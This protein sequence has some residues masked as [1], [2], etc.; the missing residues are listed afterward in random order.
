MPKFGFVFPGQGSQALKMMDGFANAEIIKSVF[1]EASSILDL[2]FWGMLQED[3]PAQINQTLNT[4][5]LLLTASV[6]IYQAWLDYSANCAPDFVAGHSL[7]EYSA[8]VA[9][10][11]LTFSTALKLVQKRAQYMQEAVK[12]GA[13]AMAAVLGLTNA[14]V[15]EVCAEVMQSGIGVVQG[16]NFNAEGQVVI[17]GNTPAVEQAVGLMKAKGARKIILLSVS[18]PSHCD[19]MREAAEQL[20]LEFKQVSFNQPSIP[21]IQNVSGQIVNDVLA[22]KD[23]LVQQ[24][25]SPVLWS[26]SVETL[27]ANRVELI[28]ECG[29]GKVLSGLNKRIHPNAQLFS[30]H[31]LADMA[32]LVQVLNLGESK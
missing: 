23:G 19:L 10:G 31:S 21:V 8:L 20:A 7:G 5:P 4:Q 32:N 14:V 29:P 6:A 3:T 30:L 25:Y 22:I 12:P 2:D 17:A 28:G 11:V 9:S 27:A 26:K 18:V 24:L 13:G 1:A 15:I 16:A